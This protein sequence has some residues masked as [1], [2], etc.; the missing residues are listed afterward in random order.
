MN[1]T[2]KQPKT[3]IEAVRYFGSPE[4]C[5]KILAEMIWPNGEAVCPHCK[6]TGAT[7]MK[8][9]RVWQCKNCRKQF[10]AKVGTIFEDSPLPLDRWLT[11]MWLIANSKNGISS[12]AIH[13]GVGVTQKTAWFMLQRIRLAMQ[14]KSFRKLDGEVEADETYIGGVARFM[15]P[16][17]REQKVKGTGGLQSGKV[18]VMGLLQRHG[19]VRTKVVPNTKAKTVQAQVRKH[20]KPGTELFTDQH[21]GY[22]GLDADYIHQVINHAESY[23]RGKVH[24][25]GMEN[26]WSLLKRCIKGTYISVEPWHLFRYLD[27]ESFRFNTRKQ[28]DGERFANVLGQVTG[29]K[30]TYTRL[31]GQTQAQSA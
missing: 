30:L 9:R 15:H 16:Y 22:K 7:Y 28:T 13:R 23:V 31:T 24:T 17:R 3:L 10:S 14:A 27:E 11:A 21:T 20:V 29:R 26:F 12:Y 4:R 18:A 5:Q 1:G 6:A 8:S 25:N 2:Q 19:E